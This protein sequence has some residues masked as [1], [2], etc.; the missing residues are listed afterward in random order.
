MA[1]VAHG[2][3]TQTGQDQLKRSWLINIKKAGRQKW[4]ALGSVSPGQLVTR[5][6]L[7]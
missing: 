7:T 6:T 3:C 1:L 5:M 2:H 4:T